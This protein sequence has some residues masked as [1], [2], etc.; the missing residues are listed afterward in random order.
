MGTRATAEHV[1]EV[2]AAAK[3]AQSPARKRAAELRCDQQ[4]DARVAA[5][6]RHDSRRD[7]RDRVAA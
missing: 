6:A 4:G 1:V 3:E 5:A 2:G 7:A